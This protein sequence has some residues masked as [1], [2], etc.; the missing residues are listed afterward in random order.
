[1]N[2]NTSNSSLLDVIETL[3]NV[4]R[5]AALRGLVHSTM[6]KCIGSIRQHMR[7]ET[8]KAR[9][10]E[11]PQTDLDQR[12][13]DD[14]N[15]RSIEEIT[16]A[17]GFDAQVPPLKQASL[18]HAA[19]DWVN[20]E[21]RTLTQSQWDA[22]L[23]VE[24][25]LKFM[26]E[27][28]PKLDGTLVKALADAIKTDV[29]TIERMHELQSLREREQLIEATPEILLTFNGFG[30]NGYESAFDDLPKMVQHQLGLKVVESLK[31]ARDQTVLRVLRSR[32]LTD[33]G[34]MPILEDAEKQ[35]TSWV[36]QFENRYA[37]DIREAI[38]AGRNLRTLEDVTRNAA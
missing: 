26:T 30:D 32:R 36:T 18:F 2:T 11:E 17:M 10:E 23:S 19:Y 33:L 15:D 16:E 25:M 21:L 8:R 12:N 5:I 4:A 7:D 9:N 28:S 20:A 3:D 14:E 22:P 27:R 35:I 31:K 37:D 6:A 1:M 29:K 13:G 24:A 34:N 38:E